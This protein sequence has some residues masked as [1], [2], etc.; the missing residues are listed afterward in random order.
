MLLFKLNTSV[1]NNRPLTLEI[2][3]SGA[4]QVSTISLDL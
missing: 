3:L 1:Y 4:S 2:Q